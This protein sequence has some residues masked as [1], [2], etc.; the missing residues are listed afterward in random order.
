MSVRLSERAMSGEDG[1]LQLVCFN[2][3]VGVN[4]TTQEVVKEAFVEIIELFVDVQVFI[5]V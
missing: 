5:A 1:I 4:F 2:I 3:I